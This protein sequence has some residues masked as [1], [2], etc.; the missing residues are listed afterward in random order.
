MPISPRAKTP[1]RSPVRR[2]RKM[3]VT[4]TGDHPSYKEMITAALTYLM[5]KNGSSRQKIL[6]YIMANYDM[7][8]ASESQ[9]NSRLKFALR[10]AVKHGMLMRNARGIGTTGKFRL[11]RGG[12]A[13][14]RRRMRSSGKRRRT[15]RR[16]SPKRMRR[17]TRR[18]RRKV[19]KKA[20]KKTTMRRRR[21]VRRA[22]KSKKAR[23]T[24]KVRSPR[25]RLRRR[26]IRRKR[27]TRRR[28]R[29]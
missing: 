16:R 28:T 14:R 9:V 8:T 11:S 17:M 10:A 26:P 19:A 21:R 2:R 1:S 12:P 24:R 7:G 4:V 18:R 20:A 22:A 29:R 5:D 25:R 15:R 13:L 6:N 27:T 23:R 3:G